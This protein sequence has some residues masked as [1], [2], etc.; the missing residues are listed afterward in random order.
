MEMS[1]QFHADATLLQGEEPT[2]PTE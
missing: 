1:I 2:V